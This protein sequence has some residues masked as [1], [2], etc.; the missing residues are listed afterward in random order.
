MN[1]RMP[2]DESRHTVT[3]QTTRRLHS[4]AQF[5]V[6]KNMTGYTEMGARAREEEKVPRVVRR[7]DRGAQY[8]ERL[9]AFCDIFVLF[10][11]EKYI[12]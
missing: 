3:A 12:A 8:R 11:V 1:D 6:T 7:R 9:L 10:H 4:L 5:E 2:M